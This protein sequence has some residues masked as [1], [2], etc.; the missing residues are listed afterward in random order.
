MAFIACERELL[1][2]AARTKWNNLDG[3]IARAREWFGD[4]WLSL[5]HTCDGCSALICD[6]YLAVESDLGVEAGRR[7]VL[8]ERKGI[9]HGEYC[10]ACC[11]AREAFVGAV[12]ADRA[13]IA[14]ALADAFLAGAQELTLLDFDRIAL[15]QDLDDAT[16]VYSVVM[17]LVARGL[18]TQTYLLCETDPP[19]VVTLGEIQRRL[20]EYAGPEWRAWA[21][22]VKA[23]WRLASRGGEQ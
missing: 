20:R 17:C 22:N 2:A 11:W 15:A 7:R 23:V 3:C 10:G 4:D 5:F 8:D 13:P 19:T 16:D 14:R 18:L 12:Q 6:E 1:E 9:V 21:R